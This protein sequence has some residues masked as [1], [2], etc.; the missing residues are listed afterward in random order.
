[1]IIPM[2]SNAPVVTPYIEKEFT[3]SFGFSILQSFILTLTAELGDKTFIMLIILQLKANQITVLCSSLVAQLSMNII[4]SC[5]GFSIDY[6]LYKNLIDY[7]GLISFL[8][9][10]IWLIGEAF[11]SSEKS[12]EKELV[13]E[14]ELNEHRFVEEKKETKDV[15]TTLTIIPEMSRDDSKFPDDTLS[16]PLLENKIVFKNNKEDNDDGFLLS[17]RSNKIDC[18]VHYSGRSNN[19]HHDE[20]KEEKKERNKGINKTMF[21]IIVKSMIIS[22]FGDRTQFTSLSMAAIYNFY[23]VVIGTSSALIITIFLGVFL[24]KYLIKYLK[25]KTLNS[26]LG[27]IMFLYTLQIYFNK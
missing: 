25:E 9:Y 18:L 3:L 4:A 1:M 24:G 19:S 20:M 5:I 21:L 11:H 26:I 6:M 7:V 2:N 27:I 13:A 14:K 8:I 17:N 23:G 15:K 22:E 10:S 16:T 12:F